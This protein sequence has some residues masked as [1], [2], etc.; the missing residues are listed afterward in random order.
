MK[1]PAGP[2]TQKKA[3]KTVP[4]QLAILLN[5]VLYS[6]DYRTVLEEGWS[7]DQK[8]ERR[9][10]VAEDVVYKGNDVIPPG[11]AKI[12]ERDAYFE[13][14]ELLRSIRDFLEFRAFEEVIP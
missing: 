7:K 14:E 9:R 5:A 8:V 6:G 12:P 13:T 2:E 4:G 10:W 1:F 3:A 11:M